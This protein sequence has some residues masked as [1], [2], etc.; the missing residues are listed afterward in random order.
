MAPAPF[1]KDFMMNCNNL[2]VIREQLNLYW[3]VV[4]TR[5]AETDKLKKACEHEKNKLKKVIS[6]LKEDLKRCQHRPPRVITQYVT[7]YVPQ[8]IY[9]PVQYVCQAAYGACNAC[10]NYCCRR[11]W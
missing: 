9:Q 3:D 1:S 2:D 11:W 6:D 8:C 7:Q 5:E 4:L 10:W